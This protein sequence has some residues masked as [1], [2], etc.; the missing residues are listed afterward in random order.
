LAV[1]VKVLDL[2]DLSLGS[3]G[4]LH[5]GPALLVGQISPTRHAQ[6]AGRPVVEHAVHGHLD[7]VTHHV[8]FVTRG[9]HPG[10][11]RLAWR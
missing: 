3:S 4:R 9:M 2:P 8:D 7:V 11:P 6:L 5:D 1:V 10:V